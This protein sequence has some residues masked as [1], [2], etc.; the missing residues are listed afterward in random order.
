MN[1]SKRRR[2]SV[3]SD[4]ATS[5]SKI[6]KSEFN[7][8]KYEK[9]INSDFLSDLDL[10]TARSKCMVTMYSAIISDLGGKEYTTFV[11]Q[12]LGRRVA[13][14]GTLMAELE[15]KIQSG[16]ALHDDIEMYL[17]LTKTQAG[18][19]R[20]LGLKRIARPTNKEFTLDEFLSSSEKKS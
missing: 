18:V 19:I 3:K 9:L 7:R 20:Q 13:V 5:P 1:K 6:F 12:E 4:P 15:E 2:L 10:R 11:Q 17:N 8:E 14:C 16:E